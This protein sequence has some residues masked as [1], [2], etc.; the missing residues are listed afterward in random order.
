MIKSMQS[1]GGGCVRTITTFVK[2]KKLSGCL[3]SGYLAGMPAEAPRK[4]Q[5]SK[6]AQEKEERSHSRIRTRT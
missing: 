6:N 2:T 3:S 1:N 5:T 4:P